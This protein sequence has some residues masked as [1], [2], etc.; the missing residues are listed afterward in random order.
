MNVIGSSVFVTPLAGG[1]EGSEGFAT[2]L[3]CFLTPVGVSSNH[4]HQH[5][6]SSS[7][8]QQALAL[9]PSQLGE[10][11]TLHWDAVPAKALESAGET[12]WTGPVVES[13]ELL[14]VG[15]LMGSFD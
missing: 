12:L 1:D 11:R 8:T 7:L 15:G 10:F 13:L 14:Q 5:K 4:S 9:T 2:P 3:D 6:R